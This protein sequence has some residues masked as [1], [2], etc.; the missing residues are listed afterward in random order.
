VNDEM[1]IKVSHLIATSSDPT[2]PNLGR[3]QHLHEQNEYSRN[4][5]TIIIDPTQQEE[6]LQKILIHRD[7]YNKLL[8]QATIHEGEEEDGP[9]PEGLHD[10]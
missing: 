1:K 6:K 2:N 4:N 10:R 5:D 7:R 3:F 9:D 8:D